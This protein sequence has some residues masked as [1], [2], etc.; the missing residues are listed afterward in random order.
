MLAGDGIR[1]FHL[2]GDLRL[3]QYHGI[4][5]AGDLHGMT[6]RGGVVVIVKMA[7]DG[8]DIDTVKLAEPFHQCPVTH[9]RDGT[10]QLGAVT[11]RQNSRFAHPRQVCQLAQRLG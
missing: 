3:T 1:F 11:G 9:L 6:N 5:A 2:P 7:G 8:I 10:I 4:Q